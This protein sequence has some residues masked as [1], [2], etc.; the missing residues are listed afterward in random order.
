MKKMIFRVLAYA[1]DMVLVSAIT[2][3]LATLSF[4]NPGY[5]EYKTQYESL[6]EVRIIYTNFGTEYNKSIEDNKIS[7]EEKTKL[8]ELSTEYS[9]VLNDYVDKD[10][11]DEDKSKITTEIQNKFNDKYNDIAYSMT[12]NNSITKIITILMTIFYFGV[13]QYVLKGR[14]IGK[15]VFRLRVVNKDD[16]NKPVP[17]YSYLLRSIIIG[18]LLIIA[19]DLITLYTLNKD[20]YLTS[21]GIINTAQYIYEIAFLIVMMMRE[22]QRSIHDLLLGTRVALFDKE[23]KEVIETSTEEDV[24]EE[25]K[26]E[27]KKATPKKKTTTKKKTTKKKE[28]VSAEKVDD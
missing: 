24:K 16:N 3:F 22:D 27:E 23:G 15:L 13:I 7:A 1:V 20:G 12:K 17:L 10:L 21:A 11:S 5:N 14:T 2:I 8:D 19:A 25:P 28:F 9:V 18:E 6:N 4:V 26:K